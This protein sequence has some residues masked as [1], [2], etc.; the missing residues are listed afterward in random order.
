MIYIKILG[1]KEFYDG[2]P[3][4]VLFN[5]IFAVVPPTAIKAKYNNGVSQ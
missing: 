4:P 3:L 5:E 2:T 1:R